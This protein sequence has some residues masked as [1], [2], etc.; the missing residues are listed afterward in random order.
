MLPNA[1]A[2]SDHDHVTPPDTSVTK[3]KG[4]LKAELTFAQEL[5]ALPAAPSLL[6]AKGAKVIAG[7]C[8][9]GPVVL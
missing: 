7:S 5:T 8:A 2:A 9:L 1:L 3:H 4:F 6:D